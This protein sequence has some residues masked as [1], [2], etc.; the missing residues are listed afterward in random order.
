MK[1]IIAITGASGDL[2]QALIKTLSAE[3]NTIIAIGR[4]K[5]RLAQLY[6]QF[7]NVE[8][9]AVNMRDDEAIAQ[10]VADIYRDYGTIN[11]FIN[12]AGFGEF[13]DFDQF[14]PEDIRE[15]FDINTLATINFSRLIGQKM[16]E[17]G[18]G[19]IINIASMAGKM[20]TA[21]AS[22]YAGTKFAVIGY[23]NALRLELA[24]KN[25]FVTTVNP[26]PIVTKFFDRADPSGNYLKAIERFSLSPEQVA[27]KM[28]KNLGK[29][30]RE[31]NLPLAMAAIAKF[32]TL[33]PGFADFLSR[34]VFNYK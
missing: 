21:K 26:G 1:R 32:Y 33:F 9:R 20:G 15:H 17:E 25:V 30:K 16:A 3:D 4:S 8:P 5:E 31:I 12:N 28:I 10:L 22:V 11:V 24:E 29:N 7:P 6:S 34:K 27:N 23:S 2:A 19:H 13:K 18:A 14:E